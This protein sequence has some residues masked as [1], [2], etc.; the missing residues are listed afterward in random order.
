MHLITGGAFNGKKKWVKEAYELSVNP[1]HWHSFYETEE[2]ER[3]TEPI[4]VFEGIE[5]HVRRLIEKEED[6]EMARQAWNREL[7]DWLRW[8][9][10]KEARQVILIGTD[11]TKGVVPINAFDRMWRDAAGWC[12]QDVAK[13]AC[14][15]IQV[16][17]GIP[18]FIKQKEEE[19]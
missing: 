16:W 19:K 6:L 18:Q 1:Y 11:I 7:G 2:I 4:L 5:R 12:F 13:Q 3:W 8:E 15:V 17:Y 14:Q 10:E 9:K